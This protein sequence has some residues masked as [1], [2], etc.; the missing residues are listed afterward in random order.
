MELPIKVFIGRMILT[1]GDEFH[2]V[3]LF[4]PTKK[5]KKGFGYIRGNTVYV[6]RGKLEKTRG[7]DLQFG[8]YI[9]K[10]GKY[11]FVEPSK[12][13]RRLFDI[14]NIVELNL[15]KIFDEIESHA[16]DFSNS[17]DIEVINNNAEVFI[18]TIREDDDFLKFIVKKMIIDKKVNLKNYKDKFPNQWSLNNMKSGLTRDTK[19]TVTN[20]KIWCEILGV[21]WQMI[22]TDA[23]S[24]K[25]NPLPYKLTIDSDDF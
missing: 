15:D 4:I 11:I 2:E 1:V 20:F 18:P 5:L 23:G 24:D 8:I 6:Y 25:S 16:E 12:E 17:E 19:M 9:N 13:E 7:L 21:K 3:E 10:E 14:S 22:V